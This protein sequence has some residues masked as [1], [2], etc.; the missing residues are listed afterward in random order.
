MRKPL[1]VLIVDD[2]ED[3]ALL[4]IR[5]LRRGGYEPNCERVTTLA[6]ME[7]ALD[8]PTWD[9]I[10]CDYAMSGF[11]AL[12]VLELYRTKGL[13]IPVIVLSGVVGEYRASAVMRAGAK[14]YIAKDHLERL[15]PT[16]ARLLPEPQSDQDAGKAGEPQDSSSW[17]KRILR[18][19]P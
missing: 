9:V 1:R 15:A 8:P 19:R 14:E 17:W 5:A 6:A 7:A 4:F 18:S 2:S 13:R 16:V 11:D 10:L 12:E 3:D